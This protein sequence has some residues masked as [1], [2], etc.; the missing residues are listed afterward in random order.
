VT[1]LIVGLLFIAVLLLV[2][3]WSG[4]R[5]LLY[6]PF[7]PVPS[8]VEAG[9]PRA[10][11]VVLKT[12]D[13]LTLEAWFVPAAS[14]SRR[15]TAIVFNG[16]GGHRGLRAPLAA[17][18]AD[19]GISTLLVDYRGYGGN[20]GSPSEEG[21]ALDAR[22]ARRYLAA[23][24]DVDA[25]RLIY[26]GESL[27]SGVAVRLALEERPLALILRSPYTSIVDLATH[28]YPFLPAGWLLRDRFPSLDRIARVACPLLVIAARH[29]SIVPS[30]QSERLY[31]AAA[32][33]KRL[34]MLEDAD[35]NDY[36]LLA[37]PKVI[38]T[39][40]EFLGSVRL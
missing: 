26:F 17:R 21:L 24:P 11:A 13:G 39:I 27:G 18:L 12:E 28:H 19:E 3:V 2:L 23:R 36:A 4:Q 16:N 8:P 29:D 7:G 38:G 33:P 10:Q 15:L 6:F 40:V 32:S 31:A 9:L 37:G 20:P 5:K 14:P 25:A 1:R 22:A 30:E 34:L 35:H